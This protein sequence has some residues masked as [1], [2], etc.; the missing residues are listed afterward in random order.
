VISPVWQAA[1][2]SPTQGSRPPWFAFQCSLVEA[3]WASSVMSTANPTGRP[4]PALD[5]R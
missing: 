4:A 2:F 3:S 1:Q 5:G